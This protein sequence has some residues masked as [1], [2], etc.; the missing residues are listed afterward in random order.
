MLTKPELSVHCDGVPLS[1]QVSWGDLRFSFGWP[2]GSLDASLRVTRHSNQKPRLL[3][4]GVFTEI[5]WG[6]W[7]IWA[8]TLDTPVWNGREAEIKSK[9]LFRLGETFH[10]FD[11]AGNTTDNPTT[12]ITAAQGRGMPW[13][14]GFGVPNTALATGTTDP[15]NSILDLMEA[16]AEKNGTRW[17]V[18]GRR[19]ARMYAD[20]TAPY[21]RVPAGVVDIGQSSEALRT[22]I[23][24]RYEHTGGTYKTVWWPGITPPT[25]ADL[26]TQEE[27]WTVSEF[28]R[29]ATFLG[30]ISDAQAQALAEQVYTRS[31]A[32]PG[33][34]NGLTLTYGQL[35]NMAG[36]P[37]H[38][39][40]VRASRMVRLDGVP[41][42]L[43]GFN[44]TDFVIGETSHEHGTKEVGINP[45]GMT[46]NT[47]EAVWTELFEQG[48]GG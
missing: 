38:P 33:W 2:G 40:S 45:V 39:A 22:R 1:S 42:E 3:Q 25:T 28:V 20:P 23:V 37:V 6:G 31:K 29:D 36:E 9:G 19:Y 5:T 16:V 13:R 30:P 7:P 43:T 18:D 24:L 14:I 8:G 26:T 34:T 11:G 44:H 32:Q 46:P 41:D 35:L 27:R 17:Q 47:P 48:D 12:A 10:A 15:V 4:I 21:Y